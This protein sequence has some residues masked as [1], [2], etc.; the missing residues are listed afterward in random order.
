MKMVSHNNE[1]VEFE[2]ELLF[3]SGQYLKEHLFGG[4]LLHQH[5]LVV[6]SG[7]YMILGTI[8]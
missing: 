5:F 3:S 2:L 8:E 6:C 1:I 4:V 7:S